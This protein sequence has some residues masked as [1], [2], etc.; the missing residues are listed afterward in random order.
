MRRAAKDQSRLSA[1]AFDNGSDPCVHPRRRRGLEKARRRGPCCVDGLTRVGSQEPST[2]PAHFPG[3]CHAPTGRGV[4]AEYNYNRSARRT[5]GIPTAASSSESTS[6]WDSPP[7]LPEN[8]S[9]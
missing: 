3:S 2:Q 9:G 1:I 4:S 8:L 7:L 6:R 5:H